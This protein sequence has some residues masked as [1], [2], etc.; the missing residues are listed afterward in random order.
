MLTDSG[1]REAIPSVEHGAQDDLAGGVP[2]IAGV[3]RRGGLVAGD[4][5]ADPVLPLELV[6]ADEGVSRGGKKAWHCESVQDFGSGI[7]EDH[8]GDTLHEERGVLAVETAHDL[9][10]GLEGAF[11]K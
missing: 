11:D 6:R 4:S 9:L 5:V 3:E 1:T 10:G 8:A 2:G 7:L